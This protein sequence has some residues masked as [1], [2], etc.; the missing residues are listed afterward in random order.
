MYR[1]Q[2]FTE[3]RVPSNKAVFCFLVSAVC[4]SIS[5]SS[6]PISMRTLSLVFFFVH[7]ILCIFLH[8]RIS[9]AL[10]FFPFSLS[11][12]TSHSQTGLSGK[13]VSSLSFFSCLCS[14]VC[15]GITF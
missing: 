4:C 12:S 2:F 14:R 5:S 1:G 7:D 6:I 8:I 9:H 13:L 10:I 11:L 3:Y 15:L